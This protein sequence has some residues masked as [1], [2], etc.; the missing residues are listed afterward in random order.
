MGVYTQRLSS[1]AEVD[2]HMADAQRSL[3]VNA[4]MVTFLLPDFDQ[5]SITVVDSKGS[6]FTRAQAGDLVRSLDR[7]QYSLGEGPCIDSLRGA[8]PVV[9]SHIQQGQRWRRYVSSAAELGLRSQVATP[10]RG[11]DGQL[12]GALNMYSTTRGDIAPP[13]PLIAE[14]LAAQI[15]GSLVGFREIEN[16]HR[17]LAARR[18]IGAAIGMLMAQYQLTETAA[19]AVLRRRSTYA[20]V[21]LGVIA[22]QMVAEGNVAG[23]E[24]P[25]AGI[26]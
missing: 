26:C 3:T 17:A 15:A 13:A 23:L 25:P 5:V 9:A 7:L 10:L 19:F 21:D 1:E 4:E 18:T 14:A 16:L 24:L 12:M 8:V 20:N 11:G 22:A 6:T 2:S